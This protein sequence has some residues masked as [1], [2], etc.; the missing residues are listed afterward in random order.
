[1]ARRKEG[2]YGWRTVQ[3][4]RFRTKTTERCVLGNLAAT[5]LSLALSWCKQTHM[6]REIRRNLIVVGR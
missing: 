2:E 4:F 5:M 3:Q 1:M 6:V